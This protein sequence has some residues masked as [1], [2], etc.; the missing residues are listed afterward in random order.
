[1]HDYLTQRGGAERVVLSLCRAFPDAPVYA[2]FY[3][4]ETTFPEFRARDVRPLWLDR[5]APLRRRHRL[6]LPLLPLAFTTSRVD[7]DVVVCSSSGWAHG[8]RTDGR[9]IVYCHSP[10]KWLYRADDYLGAHPSARA[11]VGLRALGP[12]LRRF[13]RR[14]AA[15]ADTYVANSTFIAAQIRDVY[16]IE[17]EVLCPRPASGRRR[18]PRGD[19]RASSPASCSRSRGCCRTRTSARSSTRSAGCR[20]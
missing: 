16:G 15:S 14:A 7:A 12:V 3:D 13:D 5:A 17:A 20:S 1:M 19:R 6:A 4:P 8:I 10:A 2:S 11:R 18:A 9:K